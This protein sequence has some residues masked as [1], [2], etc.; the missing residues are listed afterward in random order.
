MADDPQS[1]GAQTHH[2][3]GGL[4]KFPPNVHGICVDAQPSGTVVIEARHNDVRLHFVVDADAYEHLAA[5]LNAAAMRA[6]Q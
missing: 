5:M 2:L 1:V 6:R 4:V 3:E